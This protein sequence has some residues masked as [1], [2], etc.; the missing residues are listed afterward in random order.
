MLI[1]LTLINIKGIMFAIMV[2]KL[3]ALTT[4]LVTYRKHIEVKMLFTSLL[5]KCLKKLNITKK[6]CKK[7]FEKELVMSK[8]NERHF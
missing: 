3:Y 5:K 6:L 2:T 4:Y 7:H 8:E 1:C